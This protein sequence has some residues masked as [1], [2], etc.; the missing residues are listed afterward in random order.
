MELP[1]RSG[2]SCAGSLRAFT[3]IELLVVIAIIAILAAIMFP[4]IA[5][6]KQKA[7]LTKCMNNM[8]Q[9][10][11]AIMMYSDVYNGATPFAWN[12]IDNNWSVW[13]RDTWRERI[14]PFLKNRGALICPIKT[15][16][17]VYKPPNYPEIGHY[18]VNVYITMDDMA[19]R[20]IGWRLFSSIPRPSRTILVSENKDGD[21]SAEPLDNY[22]T[23][24]AGQFY[25]YHDDGSA[26][27]GMFIFCDGH[28]RFLS[29]YV[30][31]S[32][33]ADVPFYYWRIRK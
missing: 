32:T 7:V 21:W 31:Q 13:C 26:R 5:R 23:G 8:S 18:G 11:R 2:Q 10:S 17:P 4:V 12:L 14:Q 19:T 30:T 6:A 15:K 22:A 1:R 16:E 3:L 9:L 33:V 24:S 29:V 25:P 28:A 20:Y 27:G